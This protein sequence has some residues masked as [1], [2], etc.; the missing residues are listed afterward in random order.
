MKERK[1]YFYFASPH[2]FTYPIFVDLMFARKNDVIIHRIDRSK[3][4]E[5]NNYTYYGEPVNCIIPAQ[6][7]EYDF[8]FSLLNS[9]YSDNIFGAVNYLLCNYRERFIKDVKAKAYPNIAAD[10]IF[11]CFGADIHSGC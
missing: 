1:R 4:I 2:S 9:K 11:H 6:P 8:V 10:I 7:M 3:W 5:V